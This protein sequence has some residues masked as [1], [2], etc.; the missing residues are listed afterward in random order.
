MS[1]KWLRPLLSWPQTMLPS[2]PEPPSPLMVAGMP[3]VHADCLHHR[4]HL[5]LYLVNLLSLQVSYRC[6]MVHEIF[7]FLLVWFKNLFWPQVQN[8]VTKHHLEN[9]YMTLICANC[10]DFRFPFHCWCR[11]STYVCKTNVISIHIT[12]LDTLSV[13]IQWLSSFFW[14][15]EYIFDPAVMLSWESSLTPIHSGRYDW[16]LWH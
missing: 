7:L 14:N 6:L 4:I 5:H 2:S 10:A 12:L 8:R 1:Q 3:C 9:Q 15:N 16:S 13:P 11:T